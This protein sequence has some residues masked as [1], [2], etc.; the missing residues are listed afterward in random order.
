MITNDAKALPSK[1]SR[2]EAL[3]AFLGQWQAEGTSYGS[4][5]Q[6]VDDPRRNGVPWTST[7]TAKWY[8]GDFFLVQDERARPGGQIFDTLSVM[9][10]DAATDEIFA[11]TFENHGFCRR[12]S[13]STQGRVWIFSGEHEHARIEFSEDGRTQTIAWEWRPREK[14]LPLCDRVAKRVD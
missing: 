11:S 10:V 6:P 2:H 7:L 3:K 13:V 12:Y 1:G 9:G 8:T 4:T 5:E 14:W